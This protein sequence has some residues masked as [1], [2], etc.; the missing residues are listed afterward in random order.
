MSQSVGPSHPWESDAKIKKLF[1]CKIGSRTR[2][3][4]YC[5]AG[6]YIT[7]ATL[8]L[9]TATAH[10]HCPL[11]ISSANHGLCLS[12]HPSRIPPRWPSHRRRS[13]L[14]WLVYPTLPFPVLSSFCTSRLTSLPCIAGTAAAAPRNPCR[15][16]SS[17]PPRLVSPLPSFGLSTHVSA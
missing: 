12:S 13:V 16:T 2:T 15:S 6:C 3:R 14:P 9:P 11:P 17:V 4:L 1:L 7:S 8:P 10:C 5:W